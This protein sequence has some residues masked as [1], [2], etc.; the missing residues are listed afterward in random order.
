VSSGSFCPWLGKSLAMGYID[1]KLSV[2]G[3]RLRID[4]RGT[5]LNAT[6]VPLPFYSRAK[7]K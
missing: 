7:K 3:T 6:V 4:V 5:M 1:P 2:P